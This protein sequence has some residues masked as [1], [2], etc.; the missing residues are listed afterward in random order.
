MKA[1]RVIP[2][3]VSGVDPEVVISLSSEQSAK[4]AQRAAEVELWTRDHPLPCYDEDKDSW[5][6]G[7]PHWRSPELLDEATRNEMAAP[8]WKTERD[9]FSERPELAASRV[10]QIS[11]RRRDLLLEAG[12]DLSAGSVHFGAGR[13]L[14][15]FIDDSFADG[16]CFWSS[17]GLIDDFNFPPHDTWAALRVRKPNWRFREG[18]I[19][20]SWIPELIVPII[21]PA[22]FINIEQCI[23]WL[24]AIDD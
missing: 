20:F 15:F 9:F 14:G 16:S 10:D 2:G 12:E 21:D 8:D 7:K 19:L 4:L 13:W 24:E 22:V 18:S 3:L 11:Q 23:V 6:L 1:L 17:E 5:P